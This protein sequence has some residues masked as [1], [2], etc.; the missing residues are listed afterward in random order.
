MIKKVLIVGGLLVVCV[1]AFFF[2][3]MKKQN[4]DAAAASPASST[5]IAA[6]P[7][8]ATSSG[9]PAATVATT[10]NVPTG[11]PVQ[12]SIPVTSG[13]PG[14]VAANAGAPATPS[15]P[16][17]PPALPLPDPP[18]RI[19]LAF[20]PSAAVYDP[21]SG[22]P[23]PKREKPPTIKINPVTHAPIPV[24]MRAQYQYPMY[25]MPV[26]DVTHPEIQL[27][28]VFSGIQANAA[29]K[30]AA[31]GTVTTSSSVRTVPVIG[32]PT[33][34]TAN[35]VVE[36]PAVPVSSVDR[37][38]MAGGQQLP[39][40]LDDYTG[41]IYSARTHPMIM[42]QAADGAIVSLGL[43]GRIGTMRLIELT[44]DKATFEDVN[45]QEVRTMRLTPQNMMPEG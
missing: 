15:A 21:F 30:K 4:N 27:W 13:T 33:E 28:S 44:A 6:T 19:S 14:A 2:I 41:W 22:G 32:L 37:T 24:E 9:T 23:P 31:A 39:G 11:L 45:S 40:R 12:P 8:P 17:P 10:T 16:P 35:G 3:L 25:P 20:T 29:A 5:P 26:I 7:D 36:P 43:Q 18:A 38:M 1:A 34:N 42:L